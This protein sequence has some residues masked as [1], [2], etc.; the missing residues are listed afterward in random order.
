MSLIG[1]SDFLP[2]LNILNAV[3][4]RLTNFDGVPLETRELN[5]SQN[6]ICDHLS[7][8]SCFKS[9]LTLDLSGN[10]I[11]TM[12]SFKELYGLKK[13]NL[14]GNRIKKLV[15][16]RYIETL[17]LSHNLL[18]GVLDFEP[19]EFSYLTDLN[20]SDNCLESLKGI[21][22]VGL[23]KLLINNNHFD[24]ELRF[25]DSEDLQW[26]EL[27]GNSKKIILNLQDDLN[28][29]KYLSFDGNITIIGNF[30]RLKELHIE[31]EYDLKILKDG[32]DLHI[33][34]KLESLT[35]DN[36]GLAHDHL[37]MIIKKFPFL[38]KLDL[39][40]NL[41][42]GSFSY[43]VDFLTNYSSTLKVFNIDNNPLASY[44]KTDLQKKRYKEMILQIMRGNIDDEN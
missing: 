31:R 32:E 6:I 3:N 37:Y 19:L 36:S 4:N 11:T 1:L 7:N 24:S 15:G 43:L 17:D 42:H 8:I 39:R 41:V 20:L 44:I 33:N 29:L 35:V 18:D 21:G 12:D 27:V 34:P 22:A 2:S 9:L 14:A 28:L 23:K 26:L 30:P 40:N 5:L 38:K 13:L 25:T 10:K 16:L